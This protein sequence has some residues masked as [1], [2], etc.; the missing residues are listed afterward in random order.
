MRTI[1]Q[2][3]CRTVPPAGLFQR[4]VAVAKTEM[5][6]CLRLVSVVAMLCLIP[7]CNAGYYDG[8][9]QLR[10]HAKTGGGAGFRLLRMLYTYNIRLVMGRH[11]D[12]Y[13]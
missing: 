12:E 6:S 7:L 2:S 13:L 3:S 5:A 8:Q 11:A 9:Q 4:R 10:L 1:A